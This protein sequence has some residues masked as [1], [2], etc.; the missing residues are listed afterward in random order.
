MID[1]VEAIRAAIET[2]ATPEARAAGAAACRS[3]LA[4]LEPPAPTAQPI[5]SPEAV[6]QLAT[7]LRGMNVDQLFDV[8]IAKLR[9]LDAARPASAQVTSAPRAFTYLKVPLP[10][11][12]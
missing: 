11:A 10:S 5:L 8:A 3:I 2:E 9:T 7:V 6:A 12:K 1:F 4:A